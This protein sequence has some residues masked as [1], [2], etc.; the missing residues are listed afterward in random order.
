MKNIIKTY[1]LI[2]IL[3][4]GCSNNEKKI[5]VEKFDEENIYEE[6]MEIRNKKQVSIVT[7]IIRNSEWKNKKQESFGLM[8]Y[9]IY[10]AYV[11]PEKEM[12]SSYFSVYSDSR[13][14]II[15]VENDK[16]YTELS[17]ENSNKIYDI[18]QK[19]HK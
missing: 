5:I 6:S 16:N 10:F 1:F 7:D 15:I 11:D 18:L 3:C 2:L 4:T 9:K 14:Q 12:K 17:I 19:N 13:E 8:K